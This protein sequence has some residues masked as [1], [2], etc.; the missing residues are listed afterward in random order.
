MK[1][2]EFNTRLGGAAAGSLRVW[3]C[4]T[5]AQLGGMVL[6]IDVRKASDLR[7]VGF[8]FGQLTNSELLVN[9]K[10]GHEPGLTIP[11]S[12]LLR[13]DKVIE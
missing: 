3:P 9:L 2:R 12:F 4:A 13:A 5:R 7:P 1:R 8:P 11:E 10:T 6:Q